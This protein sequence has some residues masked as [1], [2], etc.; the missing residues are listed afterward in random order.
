M[1]K[2]IL[3]FLI[4]LTVVFL[5]TG[6]ARVPI[7]ERPSDYNSY[8]EKLKEIDKSDGISRE[9]AAIIAQNYAIEQGLDKNYIITKPA[10]EDFEFSN[11]LYSWNEWR[12][13]FKATFGESIKQGGIF[14]FIARWW[15]CV[16]VDKT[17]GEVKS[18]GGPDL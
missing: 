2:K 14:G 4:L 15:I 5:N 11:K 8:K 1:R 7:K 6:C 17:T 9:E 10:I 18:T 13:I 16:H 12:V 3:A